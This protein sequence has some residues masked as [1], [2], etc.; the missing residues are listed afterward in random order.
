MMFGSGAASLLFVVVTVVLVVVAPEDPPV[1]V[2][3]VPAAGTVPIGLAPTEIVVEDA[4][5]VV[6]AADCVAGPQP[7]RTTAAAI[8]DTFGI[9]V[10]ACCP[11]RC[12]R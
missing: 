1:V 4:A 7:A 6:S 8:K 10:I 11:A 5:T 12:G 2:V 9:A 3:T